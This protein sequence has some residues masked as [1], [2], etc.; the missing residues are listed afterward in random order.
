MPRPTGRYEMLYFTGRHRPDQMATQRHL[1]SAPIKEAIIDF[2]VKARRDFQ[3]RDFERLK[4]DLSTRFPQVAEQSTGTI[5]FQLTP[6][7]VQPPLVEQ[8]GFKGLVFHSQDKKLLAQFR[9]DGLTLN[10]LKPY[11]SWDELRPIA[12]ELWGLYCSI[13]R[14]E[15]VTR[16]ALRFINEILL[17]SEKDPLSRYITMAPL[18]PAELPREVSAFFTRTTLHDRERDLAAHVSQA[19]GSNPASRLVYVLD[20][21]AFREGAWT[22]SDP[23]IEATLEAL[24]ALK[25]LIFFNGLTETMLRQFE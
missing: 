22:P 20:I 11:T 2:R 19:F 24:R 1:P 23:D 17:P 9:I 16:L 10:R 21:D 6:T 14:P 4:V 13:A 7:G 8:G 15:G 18:V 12:I 5:T 25:N 3:P